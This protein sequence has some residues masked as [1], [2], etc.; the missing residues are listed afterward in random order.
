MSKE[1]TY[2]NDYINREDRTV[3]IHIQIFDDLLSW[4]RKGEIKKV[5]DIPVIFTYWWLINYL[6]KYAKYGE[7]EIGVTDIKKMLKLSPTT[8]SYDYIIKKG[9]LLDNKKWT[10]YETNYPI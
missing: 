1:T 7:I 10:K 6:W 3:N 9:G 8:K 5:H 4:L 2:W